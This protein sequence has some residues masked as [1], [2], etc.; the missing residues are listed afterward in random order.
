[1]GT[2]RRRA[3]VAANRAPRT[4][5][6]AEQLQPHGTNACYA[7]GCRQPECIEA[8]KQY[9][10]DYVKRRRAEG[11]RAHHGTAYGYQ[12]GCH[13]RTRCPATPS[14]AD[15]SLAAEAARR[16]AAGIPP[17]ELIDATP[18]QAHIRDPVSY[19]HLTLPTNREV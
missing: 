3:G 14:C 19:T 12:L 6:D 11:A 2:L 9:H 5:W 17:K 8:H 7:R 18:A 10:R 15:A 1:M 16:R 13:D 4:R